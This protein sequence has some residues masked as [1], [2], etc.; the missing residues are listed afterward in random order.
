MTDVSIHDSASVS[1]AVRVTMRNYL[2]SHHLYASR[3]AAETATERELELSANAPIFDIR[4]RGLVITAVMEAVAFLEAA[5]NE[6]Y[7]DAADAYLHHLGGLASGQVDLL[8]AFWAATDGGRRAKMILK[9]EVA[10]KLCGK[11]TLDRSRNP[12]QDVDRLVALRNHLMHYRPEEVGVDISHKLGE[13]LRGR[14]VV[15]KLMENS[16][17][18]SFPDIILGEGCANW[19][20][21]T[22][23][24]FAEDFA[25]ALGLLLHYQRADFGD[26][27]PA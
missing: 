9:Y 23:R 1:D 11:P 20:W 24:A 4:H 6:L 16:G 22:A 17:N 14:F 25:S 21:R 12:T 18:P 19:A 5:I 15:N 26:P 10:L 7:Q 3:Y 2:S 13:D 8:A 27:L